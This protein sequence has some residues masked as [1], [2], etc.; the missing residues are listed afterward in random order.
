MQKLKSG[1]P[2]IQ[3][4]SAIGGAIRN[5]ERVRV[6]SVR[7]SRFLPVKKAQDLLVVM[8]NAFIIDPANGVLRLNPKRKIPHAPIVQLS[9]HYD[10]VD[11]FL[12]HIPY[13][14]DML[15]LDTLTVH[16]NVYFGR[17]VILKVSLF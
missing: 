10:N 17:D 1:E 9:S 6:V 3:L 16:G 11:D 4:E 13:I 12:K 2:I 7:R 8:G 14:P 5:F 15:E